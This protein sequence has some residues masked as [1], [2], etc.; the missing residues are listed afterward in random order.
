MHLLRTIFKG[1]N[2]LLRLFLCMKTATGK[3]FNYFSQ[4][5]DMMPDNFQSIVTT[6]QK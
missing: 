5:P 3:T 6:G 2:L 4:T 1:F